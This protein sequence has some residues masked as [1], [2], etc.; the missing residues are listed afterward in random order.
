[1]TSEFEVLPEE[2]SETTPGNEVNTDQLAIPEYDGPTPGTL[3]R[4]E[5]EKRNLTVEDIVTQSRMSKETVRALEEDRDPP[6]NAWVYVRGYYRKYAR[7]LG[8]PEEEILD[9]H[10]KNSGGAPAP[11][12][13]SAEWAPQDVSP[14]GGV[15]KVV[16]VLVAGIL[17]GGLLWWAMPVIMGDAGKSGAQQQVISSNTDDSS[18]KTTRAIILPEPESKPVLT[19]GTTAPEQGDDAQAGSAVKVDENVDSLPMVSSDGSEAREVDSS[20]AKS[21]MSVIST[22]DSSD[23]PA[24]SHEDAAASN[25]SKLGLEF[26]DRSWVNI[27]DASGKKLLDGIVKANVQ[28]A[29]QGEPPFKVFLGY[30]PGVKISYAGR[31]IDVTRY[32]SSNNTARFTVGDEPAETP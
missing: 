9:A 14:D 12:S 10:E 20:P 29:L 11:Q 22:P 2:G 1:M 27:V 4:A 30:A 18:S 19:A 6:Q 25:G 32:I 28:M 13:V 31:M 15:P 8:I 7:V 16:L 3:L 5:R 23:T 24:T 17:L 26:V 21:E